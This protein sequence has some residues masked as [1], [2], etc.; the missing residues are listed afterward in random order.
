MLLHFHKNFRINFYKED[1]RDSNCSC[2]EFLY[3]VEE[4]DIIA[5]WNSLLT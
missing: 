4:N 2:T 3:L 5:I 1:C